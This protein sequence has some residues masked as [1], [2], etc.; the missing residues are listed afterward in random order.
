MPSVAPSSP[1]AVAADQLRRMLR[2]CPTWQ[3]LLRD[4]PLPPDQADNIHF[5]RVDASQQRPLAII[6]PGRETAYAL[7][8]GG[9]SN[10]LLPTGTI[11][12]YI[13]FDTPGEF[14]Q[15]PVD[16]DYYAA[17]LLG[18]IIEELAA[19]SQDDDRLAITRIGLDGWEETAEEDW[20]TL[21]RWVAG[22]ISVQWGNT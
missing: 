17:N 6:R 22:L 2:D 19:Q 7:A 12:L 21:G 10:W 20:P 16:V 18:A 9:K 4:L 14:E 5:R 13:A 1:L 8:A 15:S 11:E 3:T